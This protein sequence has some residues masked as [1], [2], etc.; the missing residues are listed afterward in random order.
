MIRVPLS[1]D[2]LLADIDGAVGWLTFD[3][4]ARRNA[5]SV[6]MWRAVPDA[7]DAFEADAAV[8]VVVLRGA[9]DK[10]FVSG[11]DI[12]Q[13]EDEF[14][15]SAAAAGLEALSARANERIRGSPRPTIA[16]IHG[17]CIGAGVQIAASCDLRIAADS[18]TL[19]ITAARLGLGYPVVSLQRLIALVGPAGVKEIFFTGRQFSAAEASAMGLVNRVVP[20]AELENA[21][22]A[23]CE[24]IAANAPLT[25]AAVKQAVDALAT[26]PSASELVACERVMKACFDSA[27]YAEGRRAFREKRRP[28]FTGR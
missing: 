24:T 4:P 26:K 6:E 11:L 15:S 22:R 13:F 8:R 28:V 25:I 7:F 16:M 3:N 10:A 2:K 9:G 21:V 12:S 20:A 17:F 27:D 19:A 23:C 18:A 5:V 1:T 14:A